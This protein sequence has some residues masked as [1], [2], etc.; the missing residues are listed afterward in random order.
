MK[1]ATNNAKIFKR[2]KIIKIPSSPINFLKNQKKNYYPKVP[3]TIE[4]NTLL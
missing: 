4:T 2:P 3:N 1:L